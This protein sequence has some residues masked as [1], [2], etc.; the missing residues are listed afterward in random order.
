MGLNIFPL[1]N[2]MHFKCFH[3]LLS[4]WPPPPIAPFLSPASHTSWVTTVSQQT[5]NKRWFNN[6]T[7][8]FGVGNDCFVF[9]VIYYFHPKCDNKGIL[10]KIVRGGRQVLSLGS[11]WQGYA[12]LSQEK[13]LSRPLNLIKILH[14]L[15][16]PGPAPSLVFWLA[17]VF[18]A[19]RVPLRPK[20]FP[21]KLSPHRMRSLEG[22]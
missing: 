10:G 1:I 7:S 21:P 2:I 9:N 17:E 11:F 16:Y 18:L 19:F 15:T 8:V 6:L 5:D 4:S 22:K 14:F 13:T 12:G 20:H 3:S